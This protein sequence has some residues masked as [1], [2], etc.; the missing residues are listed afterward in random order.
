MQMNQQGL[1]ISEQSWANIAMGFE[2]HPDHAN[3][4]TIKLPDELIAFVRAKLRANKD[5]KPG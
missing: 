2:A 3:N 5:R 4:W 1:V